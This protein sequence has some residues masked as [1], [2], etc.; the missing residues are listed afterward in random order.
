MFTPRTIIILATV[1]S[2]GIAISAHADAR[3]QDG[4][5][6]FGIGRLSCASWIGNPAEELDAK[7]WIMGYW[8]GLNTYNPNNRLVGQSTDANGVFAE[9][10][11][12]CRQH[13]SLP[14]YDAI[15]TVYDQISERVG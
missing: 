4:T 3:S 8:S 13:P 11:L 10:R 12:V 1:A 7:S 5:F 9:V 6:M 15:R 2:V 14:L